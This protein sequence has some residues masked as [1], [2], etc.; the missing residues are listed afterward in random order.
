MTVEQKLAYRAMISEVML[1]MAASVRSE[2]EVLE[3]LHKMEKTL[4]VFISG[5][6]QRMVP[7]AGPYLLSGKEKTSFRQALA[8]ALD[9]IGKPGCTPQTVL[10][11]IDNLE[12]WADN[13]IE[14]GARFATGKPQMRIR[15]L[16]GELN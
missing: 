4:Q 9:R 11:M 14:E 1:Y 12:N 15:R 8:V 5:V 2:S 7:G 13:R 6:V 3:V 16:P 10:E